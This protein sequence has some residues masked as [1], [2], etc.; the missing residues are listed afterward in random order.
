M[1]F[2]ILPALTASAL[3]SMT[4][5]APAITA[6]Q[7][8]HLVARAGDGDTSLIKACIV[9]CV[10]DVFGCALSIQKGTSCACATG[11]NTSHGGSGHGKGDGYKL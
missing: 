8:S 7:D 1:K 6:E 3:V 2:S 4:L 9:A 10:L 11:C 5:A